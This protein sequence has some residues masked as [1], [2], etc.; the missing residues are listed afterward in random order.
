M[1]NQEQKQGDCLRFIAIIQAREDGIQ[2]V[3]SGVRRSYFEYKFMQS[4]ENL[5]KQWM[6]RVRKRGVKK[7]KKSRFIEELNCYLTE[8]GMTTER[9]RT[10]LGRSSYQ[11]DSVGHVKFEMLFRF[12]SEDVK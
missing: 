4:E 8:M 11:E 9:A 10:L 12:S 2:D 6:W 1:E 7:K 3:K 5:P